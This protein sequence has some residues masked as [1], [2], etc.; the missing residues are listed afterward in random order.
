MSFVDRL[1]QQSASNLLDA[2]LGVESPVASMLSSSSPVSEL[3]SL[4]LNHPSL[5]NSY[6]KSLYPSLRRHYQWFRRTQKGL[7][8]PY[9]RRPPSRTEAYRWRGRTATHILT[10][11]LDDYPRAATPH[12]G[13]L[14]VDLMSWMGFFAET[15]KRVAE[16]LGFDDDVAEYTKH[17][18]GVM[19]NLDELH[20]SDESQAFCDVTVDDDG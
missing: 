11:G 7:L 6:L 20:W 19:A 5:A 14:H 16:Y 9:G 1:E 3:P 12:S 18:R 13:E 8:K 4:H 2:Q 15:M 17:H 10:S